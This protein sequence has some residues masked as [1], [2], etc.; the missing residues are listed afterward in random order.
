[1]RLLLYFIEIHRNE[2]S[3]NVWQLFD[4]IKKA[5]PEV[6][7]DVS[8]TDGGYFTSSDGMKYKVYNIT[9]QTPDGFPING[10]LVCSFCG[11]SSDPE[12]YYD[13]SLI[14]N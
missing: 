12:S 3:E 8:T 10:Q 1:M 2:L 7:L 4:V 11:P 14:L 5:V 9:G 13:M 6:S